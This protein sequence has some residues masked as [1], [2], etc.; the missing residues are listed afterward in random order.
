MYNVRIFKRIKHN[1][2]GQIDENKQRI[3]RIRKY[4]ILNINISLIH[5]HL[6]AH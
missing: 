2:M 4:N 1:N 3:H 5:Q 6:L